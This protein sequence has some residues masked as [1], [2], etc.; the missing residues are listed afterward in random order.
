MC[1]TARRRMFPLHLSP[2]EIF[3]LADDQLRHPMTFVIQ[4]QFSGQIDRGAFAAAL[5]EALQRHPL[6][7]S[8]ITTG[9]RDLP[10]WMPA[11]D[12]GPSL[13]WRAEGVPIASPVGEKIDL[14]REIGLRVWVRQGAERATVLL[15]F[16]HACCD[17]TGA[18]RFIGDLLAG[19]GIRTAS[20]DD[21]PAFGPVQP[22]LLRLRKHRSLGQAA[23]SLEGLKRLAIHEG[24]KILTPRPAPL[25][26][27][28]A[29]SRNGSLTAD[30]PGFLCYGFDRTEHQQF[31]DA[32]G[33][34]GATP[35]D[36]LLR[37]LFL[38]LE[39][40][41]RS[42]SVW[43]RRRWLRIMMP[44]DLRSGDDH[45]MP[46]AN[47]TGYT[48]LSR[49]ASDCAR[50]DALLR[51]IRNETALIKYRRSGA[52]FMDTLFVASQVKWL[53]PLLLS[54]RLCLAT[55]TLSNAGDPSRRFTA[56]LPRQS[57]RIVCGDLLLE[58]ITGVPPL[59]AQTRATVSVSQYHRRLTVSVRC[60]PHLFRQQDTAAFLDLYVE[61]LRRSA[62]SGSPLQT[63]SSL[64]PVA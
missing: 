9:K 57:G 51:S 62:G 55:A 13:D 50:P 32:A 6:L 59:R 56:R 28:S 11:T 4:L 49:L 19:Y 33:R 7:Q 38:A 41:N 30:F 24:W 43:P 12:Q 29:A 2:I 16:H 61:H 45:E 39:Q 3:M 52:A 35:N 26:P 20:A 60:D 58:E 18:Y 37:D 53:L 23:K 25:I 40:W 31:R 36:L 17:G 22:D 64:L 21:R 8:L 42:H 10:C 27:P 54:R 34:C 48:F 47:M 15:Q 63:A 1:S 14:T 44:T 5:A 46:A